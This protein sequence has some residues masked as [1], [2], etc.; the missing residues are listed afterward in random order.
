MTASFPVHSLRRQVT[1]W[2]FGHA[3][4][5]DPSDDGAWGVVDIYGELVDYGTPLLT[6]DQVEKGGWT[7]VYDP[8]TLSIYPESPSHELPVGTLRRCDGGVHAIKLR[9]PDDPCWLVFSG[10]R[11]V[12]LVDDDHVEKWAVVYVPVHD[13]FWASLNGL[14]PNPTRP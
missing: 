7:V 4:L 3:I 8:R 12:D 1:N 9:Q 5:L 6:H 11:S 10:D 14:E 13:K 2:G